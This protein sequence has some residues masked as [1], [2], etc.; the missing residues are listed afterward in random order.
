MKLS[1]GRRARFMA[2]FPRRILLFIL[3]G[4]TNN[5]IY[6]KKIRKQILSPLR[7]LT[8]G[9]VGESIAR[10]RP[11]SEQ[12]AGCVSWW[13]Q[14]RAPLAPHC[15]QDGGGSALTPA[16]QGHGSQW[17]DHQLCLFRR[18]SWPFSRQQCTPH[19][20]RDAA[21]ISSYCRWYCSSF[22]RKR[23]P[24]FPKESQILINITEEFSTFP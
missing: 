1:N 17:S 10:S 21:L 12:V 19:T 14:S 13:K 5:F 16:C 18:L 6:F 11:C 22:V 15:P 3:F 4:E 24:L 20:I 8:C 7:K 9:A 23:H 2:S